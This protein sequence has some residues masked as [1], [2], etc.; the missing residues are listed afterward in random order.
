MTNDSENDILDDDFEEEKS[1]SQIKREMA[2]LRDLGERITLLQ[3]KELI[4]IPLNEELHYQVTKIR[5]MQHREA[6]RRE[7]RY[8]AKLMDNTDLTDVLKA[9]DEIANGNKAKARVFHALEEA[10]DKLV[11]GQN[12]LIQ[13]LVEQYPRCDRQHLRQL[14]RN[15][16]QEF[17]LEKAPTHQRKLFRYLR[18]LA[19]D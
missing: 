10:R 6:R 4:Q 2:E 9:L 16:Q 15:A 18:E 13:E 19:D 8:L 5:K 1:K 14:V 7:I 12:E 11:A 17:K 3:K